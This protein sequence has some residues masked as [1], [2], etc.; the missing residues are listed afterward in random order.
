MLF[1][2]SEHKTS[3]SKTTRNVIII[4]AA[5]VFISAEVFFDVVEIGV[6]R[7]LLLTNP[8]RPRVG[9]LW[10][11]DQKEQTGIEELNS[12]SAPVQDAAGR[13]LRSLED[14]QA[15]LSIRSSMSMSRDEFKDFYKSI[16]IKQAKKMIDPL[17]LI[18]LDRTAD[19]RTTQLSLSGNQLVIYFL[20]GYEEPI[21][22]VHF[23]ID[24]GAEVVEK[25]GQSTLDKSEK[26]KGRV[27]P[28]N[29]FFQA[30]D[31]LPRSFRLQIINDPYKLVQW[32]SSLSR[33]GISLFVEDE[34]V[35]IIFQ[36]RD[37]TGVKHYSMYAS[38]IAVEYLI[39]EIN[40]I[41]EAPTLQAPVRRNEQT[42]KD[43]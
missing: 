1:A 17:D 24:D 19:W 34:G 23:A 12:A 40:A 22:Q 43:N 36:V 25:V 42:E 7:L 13:P 30:F 11:E 10:E 4:A 33:V 5:L 21:K 15:V 6:G 16:P 41:K 32:G 2:R 3:E 28:A 9:R 14:L 35:E 27:I 29:V 37:E 20:D 31:Q 8:L 26:F 18:E 38:E 39:N